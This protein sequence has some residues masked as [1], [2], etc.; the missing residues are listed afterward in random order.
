MSWRVEFIGKS[1]KDI[2]RLSVE[3]RRR[4]IDRLEWLEKNFDEITPMPL[5]GPWRGYFKFR[6]G[7]WRV[8]YQIDSKNKSLIV[9]YI[10]RRDKIYKL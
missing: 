10:D 5:G 2:S 4:V 3:D 9:C 6:I 7:D 8:V 1:E